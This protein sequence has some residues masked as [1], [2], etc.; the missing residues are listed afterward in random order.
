MADQDDTPDT[1]A[2]G[3]STMA[4]LTRVE[5]ALRR[6]EAIQA[7]LMQ[8]QDA[9]R[10]LDDP[11]EIQHNAS[12]LLAEHLGVNRV[13]YAEV[14][15]EEAVVR[16]A[17]VLGVD[18]PPSRI[19]ITQLGASL[20]AAQGRGE[21]IAIDDVQMD[22]RVTEPERE[23]YRS[24]EVAALASILIAKD[25]KW[26]GALSAQSKV[27]R[28]WASEE[29]ALLR[30]VGDRMRD[31]MARARAARAL[32]KSEERCR[33]IVEAAL[34]YAIFTTD[35][36]G[37]I[38]SWSP[39]ATTVFG[40]TAA[41]AIGKPFA[42]TFTM[43]DRTAGEPLRELA[44]ARANGS[45]PDRRWHQRKDGKR[46]FIDGATH[47]LS[48]GILGDKFV[49]IG[50]DTTQRREWEQSLSDLN[51]LLERR[52]VEGASQ[53]SRAKEIRDMLRLQLAQAEE[54]E[55][56]RLARE[57]HDELGQHLTAIALGLQ[58]LSDVATPNSEIDRRATQLQG[59]VASL[60][61][62]MHGLAMRLRPKALDDF[63][64][65]AALE[66]YVEAWSQR[67]GIIVDLHAVQDMGRLPPD[68]ESALYR[69]VQ[70]AL[71]NVAKHSR[72]T[73]ASIVVEQREGQVI[74][75]IEDNGQGFS[76]GAGAEQTAPL[77]M[78]LLG[79]HER[80]LLLGG[81]AQIES[82]VGSGTTVYVRIPLTHESGW[83]H[84]DSG[85]E[86]PEGLNA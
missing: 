66:A 40:W 82:A 61:Q 10:E 68:L 21:T 17:Y 30:D 59:L 46:V 37:R 71:T 77:G 5:L 74:A 70:E 83:D 85:D 63:G 15:G 76:A 73:R 13:L 2:E 53:L 39:G 32:R 34:T 41:E 57:L 81:T 7:F 11:I 60:S 43:E 45:T 80:A 56:R 48:D 19:A 55:R 36:E 51:R 38:E 79:I 31:T 26:I 47:L 49:K 84:D 23:A 1:P 86:S 67:S 78:G 8:L 20:H 27:P 16:S 64:L 52:V 24:A 75:I 3:R 12:R 28:T 65:H 58:A 35:A 29:I 54:H 6:T 4:A 33:L 42:L 18:P 14:E 50:Q 44:R 9:T 62:E 72:A 22:A 25:G 69:V